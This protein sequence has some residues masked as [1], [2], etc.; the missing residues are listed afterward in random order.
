[1][2]VKFEKSTAV[3]GVLSVKMSEGDYAAEVKD[4]L[5][6]FCKNA[7]MPG[8]RKGHV[9]MGLAQKMYGTQAKAE[10]VN[11][12]LGK[13]I[14]DYVKEN[15][16]NILGEPLENE[17]QQP[18]DIEN[19]KDFEFYFDIPLAPEMK[20]ELTSKDKVPYYDIQV[21]D[22]MVQSQVDEFCQRAGQ[23]QSVDS[24]QDRD[25][26]RGILGAV[27]GDKVVEKA[28]VMPTYFKSDD[29]KKLFEGA[30]VNDV[31]TFDPWVAYEN[32]DTEI[33][34]LLH[35]KKEEL[36]G[37]KG[38]Y[39]F[40]I[41]EISR[42]VPSEVNQELFDKIYGEGACKDEAEF[43]AKIKE[44]MQN[45]LVADS[46]YRFFIDVRELLEKQQEKA[47]MPEAL[48]RRLMERNAK[49]SENYDE[50]K[51]EE[52]FKQ[53]VKYLKWQL[54]R[55]QLA[56]QN[57]IK[58][59]NGEVQQAAKEAARYQFM[60]YGLN[61]IPDEYLEN[62][63]K[64][65]LKNREQVNQLIEHVMTQKLIQALKNVVALDHKSVTMEEFGKLSEKK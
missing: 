24:Y 55:E 18:Q 28:S 33:A 60:Q 1:M 19:G 12:L 65:T 41:E 53:G 14:N 61:N 43:R 62:Y 27:E 49:E 25:I 15:K 20:V 22:E 13:T 64:E 23:N 6:K 51:F 16:L 44:G 26:V 3:S 36:E 2:E 46:D 4:Q 52:E 63:A 11:N 5:K 42:Y 32:N 59:E 9:P 21:S 10:A 48:L 8:F 45:Q 34:S 40:Q 7:S 58:I 37:L 47:E 29:A 39:R 57:N 54:I 50:T 38:E 31:V 35:V 17:Q 56:E 30:K